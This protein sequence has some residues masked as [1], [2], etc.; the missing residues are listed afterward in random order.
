MTK[1]K[2][3]SLQHSQPAN[4]KAMESFLEGRYHAQQAFEETVHKSG[5]MKESEEEFAKGISYLQRAIEEDP[6]YVPAY[7]ELA[8]AFRGYPPHVDLHD[9]ARET[10]NKAL[11]LDETNVTTHLL[12]AD[13]LFPSAG[14]DNP[15]NHYKRVFELSPDLAEGHEAYAEYLDDLGRFGEGMKEHQKAQELDA[16]NDYIGRSPLTPLAVRLEREKKFMLTS[17]PS[18]S[19]FWLRGEL[20]YEAGRCAES[21]RDWG[22]LR[23]YGWN[24]EAVRWNRAYEKGGPQAFIRE[25]MKVFDEIAKD[26]W[27]PGDMIIAAHRYA[28]DREGALAWLETAYK[29]EDASV[30]RHLGSDLRWNAYRSDPRFQDIARRVGLP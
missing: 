7:L 22:T 5:T 24:L 18:P 8:K 16:D 29:E 27:I 9:K 2:K 25:V 19:D 28:G 4:P 13:F 23:D 26:R 17:S 30:L 11:S 10:L 1:E 14:E 3:A 21:V 20:E 6:N 15:E 12:I